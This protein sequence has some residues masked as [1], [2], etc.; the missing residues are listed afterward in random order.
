M[1]VLLSCIRGPWSIMSV[2]GEEHY[3]APLLTPHLLLSGPHGIS[4]AAFLSREASWAKDKRTT[5][6][7]KHIARLILVNR[8]KASATLLGQS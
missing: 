3:W 1:L 5:Q 7:P 2:R 4:D 8:S 6:R